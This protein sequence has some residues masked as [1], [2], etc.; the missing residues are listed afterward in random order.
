MKKYYYDLHIHSCLSPC[1]DDESTPNSIAGIG[2][3]NSLE[4]MALTDHNT[5]KNCPAFFEAAFR[6]GILPV[7]GME[8]TTAEDIHAICLFPSLEKAMEFDGFLQKKRILI[9][10]RTDIFGRQ[11]ICD[12]EDNVIGE[13]QYL[14]S[15]ATDIS[16][17]DAPGIVEGFDGI[18]YPAHID[19]SA[20]GII[21]VL[22]TFPQTPKFTCAELHS[23]ENL[24]EYAGRYSLQNKQIIISSDAH[25]LWDIK[26]RSDFLYLEEITDKERAGEIIIKHL[27]KGL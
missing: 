3:I 26:E 7:A 27:R 8:L 2:E 19:R 1:G 10:N 9:P 15:N 13:E 11:I 24:D 4:I 18:C 20:N 12:S 23:G 21:S 6:H 16:I 17:E 25:Y 14:L 5:C 22:G